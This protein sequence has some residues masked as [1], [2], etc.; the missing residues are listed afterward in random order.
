MLNGPADAIDLRTVSRA[1]VVKLRHH[2]DVSD[3][4]ALR[5]ML[6]DAAAYVNPYDVHALAQAMLELLTD[7]RKRA[8]LSDLGLRRAAQFSWKQCAERTWQVLSEAAA[9]A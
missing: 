7:E 4:P 2:G 3:I 8:R 6:S 9:R 5:E 1:L